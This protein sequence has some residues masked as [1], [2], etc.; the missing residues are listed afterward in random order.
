[1]GFRSSV[2][3]FSLGLC[4]ALTIIIILIAGHPAEEERKARQEYQ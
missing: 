1:M 2:T 4:P 3:S